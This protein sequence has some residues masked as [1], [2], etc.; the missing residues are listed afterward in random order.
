MTRDQAFISYSHQDRE[1]LARLRVH[2]R[3]FERMGL[4]EVWVDTRLQAGDEWRARIHEA[5]DRASVAVLLISAD[6]LAS[7]FISNHELPALLSAAQAQ[8]VRI[9][10]VILKPCAFLDMPELARFKAINDPDQPLISL[11]ESERE[12]VWLQVARSVRS[13]LSRP[14]VD[15]E[16][17]SAYEA[18]AAIRWDDRQILLGEELRNPASVDRYYVYEYQHLDSLG[19]MP[20]ALT[21][22]EGEPNVEEI[23]QHVRQRLLL[24]G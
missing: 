19:Y 8:G 13:A 4:V 9:L 11:S 16:E 23:L 20:E 18:D 21:V 5:I 22:L 15:L 24:E 6:F 14:E 12:A 1:H 7:D 2:M 3:P 10:P 17:G